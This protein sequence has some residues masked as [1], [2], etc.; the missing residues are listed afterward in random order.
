MMAGYFGLVQIY[1][2]IDYPNKR[3]AVI[4]YFR[5]TKTN[6]TPKPISNEKKIESQMK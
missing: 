1:E 6:A 5:G 4:Q 3:R 2:V